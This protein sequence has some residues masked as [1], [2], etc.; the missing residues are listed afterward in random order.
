MPKSRPPYPAAFRQQMVEL[1]RSV[2]EHEEIRRLRREKSQAA[3]PLGPP[4]PSADRTNEPGG[5]AKNP[6]CWQSHGLGR[7]FQA[8]RRHS[9]SS[10]NHACHRGSSRAA[11]SA[12]PSPYR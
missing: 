9:K 11:A 6:K 2:R 3:G 1:V 5:R 10:F 12:A 4:D 7:G 8:L